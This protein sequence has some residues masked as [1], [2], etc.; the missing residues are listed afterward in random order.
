MGLVEPRVDMGEPQPELAEVLEYLAVH[1]R[2]P[3]LTR[4]IHTDGVVVDVSVAPLMDEPKRYEAEDVAVAVEHPDLFGMDGEQIPVLLRLPLLPGQLRL[5]PDRLVALVAEHRDVARLDRPIPVD[6]QSV[7]RVKIGRAREAQDG[8]R[9]LGDDVLVAR[10]AHVQKRS[11][12]RA[13]FQR[14]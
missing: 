8:A 9:S 14:R 5:E 7:D 2:R 13:L 11:Y 3:A 1:D 4:A 6:G 12:A 10:I